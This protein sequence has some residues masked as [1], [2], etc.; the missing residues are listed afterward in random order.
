MTSLES[1]EMTRDWPFS[2]SGRLRAAF[3][4]EQCWHEVPGGTGVA[5]IEMARAL[6]ERPDVE[7]IGVAAK[8]HA[9]PAD[10]WKP[11]IEVAH[12]S[13]GRLRM[14]EAWHRFRRGD[15]LKATGPGQRHPRHHDRDPAED[16]SVG[17]DH[18]RSRVHQRPFQLH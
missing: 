10:P 4:L 12:L 1:A 11:P 15:V 7:L 14:Y 8:H 13:M 2:S 3:T 6:A 5:G 9:P 17:R 16:S 18:P